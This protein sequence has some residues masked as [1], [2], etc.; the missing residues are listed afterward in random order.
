MK[1]VGVCLGNVF[2]IKTNRGLG[3]RFSPN[4]WEKGGEEEKEEEVFDLKYIYS[5]KIYKIQRP[6]ISFKII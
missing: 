3:Q 5:G 1:P 6:N 4:F 2:I